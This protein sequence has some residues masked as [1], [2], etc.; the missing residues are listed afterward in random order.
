MRQNPSHWGHDDGDEWPGVL[1]HPGW[2]VLGSQPMSTNASGTEERIALIKAVDEQTVKRAQFEALEFNLEAPGMVRVINGS[3]ADPEDHTYRVN[4]E[5]GVPVACEC[6]A[7]EY[8][9]SPC[10]HMVA[11][12]IRRPIMEAADTS[13]LADGGTLSTSDPHGLTREDGCPN[14]QEGCCGPDG[15]DLPCFECYRRRAGP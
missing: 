8:G 14:G 13:V 12:A 15:D 6:P 10:K 2:A 9:E 7:F 1:E 11:V 3:H 5:T 4:V